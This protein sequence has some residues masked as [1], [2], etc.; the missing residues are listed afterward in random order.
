MCLRV[1]FFLPVI[2]IIFVIL[3][4]ESQFPK[5]MTQ[6]LAAIAVLLLITYAFL[7]ATS[8]QT[9]IW[10]GLALEKLLSCTWKGSSSQECRV[11]NKGHEGEGGTKADLC[12]G[13]ALLSS[14]GMDWTYQPN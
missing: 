7:A 11:W 1:C 12:S 6:D 2:V 4:L 14:L 8:K 10:P 3:S 5:P 13:E 9:R